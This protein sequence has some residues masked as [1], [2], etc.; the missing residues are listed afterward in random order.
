MENGVP[1][2]VV[3]G[4]EGGQQVQHILAN[5]THLVIWKSCVYA[6]VHDTLINE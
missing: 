1:I 2:V 4:G 6:N 5:A 3:D